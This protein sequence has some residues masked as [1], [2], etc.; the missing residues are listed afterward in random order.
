MHTNGQ[1]VEDMIAAIKP[2]TLV[3]ATKYIEAGDI[4]ELEAHGCMIYGENRVQDFLR[5]YDAYKGKGHWH[6]IGTLQTNKIR[7]IID[8]VELIHSVA[9][10]RIIDEIEKQAAKRDIV[11]DVLLQVNIARE[12]SK[13]GFDE[14]EMDDVMAHLEDK[15]HVHPVGLMMMAP[16][17]EPVEDTRVY[18]L[19]T[20]ELLER[21]QKDHPDMKELSMGMSHD[22]QIAL[23]EG[24]TLIRVGRALYTDETTA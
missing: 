2:A 5:K 20:R 9:N 12:E 18:F 24:A 7:Q 22:W 6:F 21:L 17:I 4:D 3:A 16:N 14:T 10:T 15:P 1:A 11:M 19:K 23:E 13:H 8:K